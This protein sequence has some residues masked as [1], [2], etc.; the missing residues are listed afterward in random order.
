MGQCNSERK[1]GPVPNPTQ[2][3][4]NHCKSG[5]PTHDMTWVHLISIAQSQ[6]PLMFSHAYGP[7]ASLLLSTPTLSTAQP[8]APHPIPSAL[9]ACISS[10]HLPSYC[11]VITPAKHHH[12]LLSSL[13]GVL[14]LND[15]WVFGKFCCLSLASSMWMDVNSINTYH[16]FWLLRQSRFLPIWSWYSFGISKERT[17]RNGLDMEQ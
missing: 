9:F 17:T 10:H 15:S 14:L 4:E 8:K 11:S 16:P 3:K 13:P 7:L 6:A 12:V 1:R 2:P 5:I